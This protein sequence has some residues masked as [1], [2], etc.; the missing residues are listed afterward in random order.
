[1]LTCWNFITT[2]K[3]IITYSASVLLINYPYFY[4]F[5]IGDTILRHIR[6]IQ[7]QYRGVCGIVCIT[8]QH[9]IIAEE[10]YDDTW[11]ARHTLSLDGEFLATEDE[12]NGKNTLKA[13]FPP[14]DCATPQRSE[15]TSMLNYSGA[16]LRGLREYERIDQLAR[17]LTIETKMAL[18]SKLNWNI[19]P[20]MILGLAESAVLSDVLIPKTVQYI[21][22][23]RI[24]IAYA[25]MS[26]QI[27]DAGQPYDYD[28]R[29]IHIAHTY[30]PST[31]DALS[32]EEAFAP[33]P[34][35]Q[36][37][38]P[39]DCVLMDDYLFIADSGLDATPNR[40]H[41]WQID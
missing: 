16:R 4:E 20:P 27:D 18:T 2:N 14:E 10:I 21:V 6:T 29:F 36:R 17:P 40:I 26:G 22:C 9:H 1:M 15:V 39:T 3:G 8:P 7:L 13:Y 25:L 24:G 11:L 19:M 23:R 38:Q 32:V 33:L 31:Q 30:D 12:E 34:G 5:F 35:V 28:T 41:I 37:N